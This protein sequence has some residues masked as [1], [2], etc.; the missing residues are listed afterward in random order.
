MTDRAATFQG[1]LFELV[2]DVLGKLDSDAPPFLAGRWLVFGE[3]A[4]PQGAG[5]GSRGLPA[6]VTYSGGRPGLL[7]GPSLRKG[8]WRGVSKLVSGWPVKRGSAAG[9]SAAKA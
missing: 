8:G 9:S 3:F 2:D 7:K 5:G 1:P 4:P 6:D